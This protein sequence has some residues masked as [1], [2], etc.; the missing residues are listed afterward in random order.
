MS[1]T[2]LGGNRPLAN[3]PGHAS[4]LIPRGSLCP[5]H[6]SGQTAV[7]MPKDASSLRISNLE[8]PNWNFNL[9]LELHWPALAARSRVRMRLSEHHI[10]GTDTS[11]S[12][13]RRSLEHLAQDPTLTDSEVLRYMIKIHKLRQIYMVKAVAK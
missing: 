5:R 13:A 7:W 3:G 12:A 9:K 1:L 10:T 6:T 11:T 4:P 8:G 2:L